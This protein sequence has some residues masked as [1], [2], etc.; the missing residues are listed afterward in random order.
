MTGVHCDIRRCQL[1]LLRL[2]I[3]RHL[4]RFA[5]DWS[6]S[7]LHYVV[8]QALPPYPPPLYIS[9]PP[10]LT[11]THNRRHL[12]ESAESVGS[13]ADRI[14]YSAGHIRRRIVRHDVTVRQKPFVAPL[15]FYC[16]DR[17]FSDGSVKHR[18]N[19]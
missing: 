15:Q 14:V 19:H 17:I 11:W 5:L 18:K 12:F 13:H 10:L 16:Y 3:D 8:F 9:S 2:I 4:D 1:L 6:I 7:T